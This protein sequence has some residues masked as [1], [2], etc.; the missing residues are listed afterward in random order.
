[1]VALTS[2][3]EGCYQ[4]TRSMFGV[5]FLDS[6]NRKPVTVSGVT[7]KGLGSDSVL[8][9]NA[10]VSAIYLPLHTTKDSTNYAISFKNGESV[11]NDTIS[12]FHKQETQFVSPACGCVPIF[13]VDS[14]KVKNPGGLYKTIELNSP[15]VI[16][17]EQNINVKIYF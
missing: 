8:Y 13:K 3:R 11:I 7:V 9:N 14:F 15:E 5:G 6:L 12:V 10:S 4:P 2:C 17:V 16:N 1:M